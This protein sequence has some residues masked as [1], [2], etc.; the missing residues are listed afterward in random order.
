MKTRTIIHCSDLHFGRGCRKE[1]VKGLLR[2]IESVQPDAVIVSGDLTMRAR[3]GQFKAAR[4]FLESISAP[5]LIIPGNHD[6]PLFSLFMRLLRPF[7]NYNKWIE[8]LGAREIIFDE[9]AIFCLNTIN[10]LRH[11]QGNVSREDLR[12]TAE[13]L[14]AMAGV[15]WRIVVMHQHLANVPWRRRP[16]IIRD[17][18]MIVNALAEYKAHAILCGHVHYHNVSPASDFFPGVKRPILLITSGTATHKRVRGREGETNSF[19][20]LTF[21]ADQFSITPCYWIDEK[22]DY[23]PGETKSFT[24]EYFK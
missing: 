8:G 17:A 1:C 14:D 21:T 23:I 18:A 3:N 5:R 20:M 7:G 11:Q 13:W 4:H 19:N 2:K 10:Y 15:P 12:K 24:R 6:V 22:Q 9:A 16:G